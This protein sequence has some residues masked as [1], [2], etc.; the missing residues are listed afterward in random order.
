[1]IEFDFTLERPGFR[2][3]L[4]GQIPDRGI[5]SLFGRSGCG[6]T[7]LLRCIAG[8]EPH[9]KGQLIVN[10]VPWQHA[11]LFVPAH[12]RPVGYVFQE[13]ALF[14]HLTVEQNLRYGYQRIPKAERHLH[15]EDVVELLGLESFLD[16]Y[17]SEMSGGQ[18]Q[19]VAIGR[20][21]LTSPQLLL[22]DEPLASLDEL[23]KNDILPWLDKL[24]QSLSIPV[25]YVTHALEEVARLAD[26]ML[27]LEQGRLLASGTPAELMTRTDLPLAHADNATSVIDAQVT[28]FDESYHLLSL[29]FSGGQMQVPA[30]VRPQQDRVRVRVAARDVAINLVQ[31][32]Q[33]SALNQVPARITALC[34]DPHPAHQLV[35]LALGET[36]LLARITRRSRDLLELAP[37][38]AVVVQ[39]KAVAVS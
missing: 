37:G 15:P 36:K 13:G 27:M 32:Q 34:D 25:I 3:A 9:C 39:F 30:R 23:S 6:K 18:R 26:H 1:M 17:A 5:T 22:M 14:S 21:L 19:R 4:E 31:Q 38:M 28:D 2:L 29:S 16:R 10:G 33:G 11:E 8:L 35:V 20:A 24:H 12:R 7:T